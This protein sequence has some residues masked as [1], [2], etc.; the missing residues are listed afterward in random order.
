MNF[1][2]RSFFL[3]CERVL[4][5]LKKGLLRGVRTKERECA[6]FE[7]VPELSARVK[8]VSVLLRALSSREKVEIFE[9]S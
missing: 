9:N 2:M 7:R 8:A 1:S 6:R 4:R 3:I 5:H